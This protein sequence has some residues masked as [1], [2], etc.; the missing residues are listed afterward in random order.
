MLGHKLWQ[1]A[2]RELDAWAT[3]RTEEPSATTTAVLDRERVLTGVRAED[4]ESVER[5]IEDSGADAIVNC[6]GVVKQSE[7]ASDPI[8]S[9]QINSLFPHQVAALC[10]ERGKRFVHISTD[11][12]FS[13]SGGA[14]AEED[15]A[16]ASDLYGRSKLLGEASGPGSLTIRTSIIGRELASSYGL[17]EWFLGAEGT[18]RGFTRAIFS[19]FTTEALSRTLLDVLTEHPDLEGLWHVSAEPID[20]Y[21][22]LGMLAEAYGTTVQIEADDSVVV[23]RSLDSTR[24]REALG[25]KPPSWQEMV[26]GLVADPTPYDEIRR[27]SLAQR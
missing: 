25:W 15:P 21:R 2:S 13:G 26:D 12:V 8:P 22:L 18:V 14:Y 27:S 19:G 1:E 7:A 5:A 10:R 16:D 24:F 4:L 23:D 3:V 17:L 11:C 20:K 6:I 9:I